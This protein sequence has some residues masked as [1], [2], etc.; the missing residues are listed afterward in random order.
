LK[1]IILA[2]VSIALVLSCANANAAVMTI[3]TRAIN[4]GINNNDFI[5]SWNNQTSSIT[6]N[7]LSQFDMYQSGYNSIS[8]LSVDFSTGQAGTWGFQAGL[9]A[10]HGAAFYLDGVLIGNRTDDLW[11]STDWN[12]SDVLTVLGTTLTA[13][14]HTLDMYW[15]ENCCNGPSSVRFTADGNTWQSLSNDNLDTVA[16]VPVPSV[17]YLFALG[18]AGLVASRRKQQK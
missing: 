3:E 9:D 15:A 10:G 4:S 2:I 5:S 7:T 17:A 12:N 1:K 18:M 6:T 16:A 13:G 8:H 11:W 14:M